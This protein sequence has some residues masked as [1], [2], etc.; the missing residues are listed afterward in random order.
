M[1]ED[2]CFVAVI[3]VFVVENLRSGDFALGVSE[4]LGNSLVVECLKCHNLGA[5]Y[6]DI[7]V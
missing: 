5:R 2:C 7:Q 4:F 1:C 6:R 3:A